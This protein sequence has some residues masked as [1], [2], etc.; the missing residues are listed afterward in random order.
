MPFTIVTQGRFTSAGVGVKIPT[1]SSVDYF[2]TWNITQLATTQAT[3]RVV[4]GEYFVGVNSANDGIRWKKT[5][6]TNVLNADLFST[7]TASDGFN[8]VTVAPG[9]GAQAPNAI[10]GIT[11][12]NPAVVT[13]TNTYSEGDVIRIY[14]TTGMLQ[15]AGMDFQISSVS[16]SGYTLLGLPATTSNG[17]AVAGTAGNTRRI[18]KI[19]AV[20]PETLYITNI[21]QAAA[22]VISTSVDPVIHYAVGMK[23]RLSVPSSMGMTQANNVTATI[24]AVNAV[25]A[26]GNIGAYNLTTDLDS[27]AFTAF[28]F[29]ASTS[30]PTAVLF[31]TLAPAG[32]K[33]ATNQITGVT[34]G[35]DFNLQPF[36]TGEF[37]PFM[38]L[39]GGAQSPA[40]SASDVIVWQ[41]Y[42]METG[43]IS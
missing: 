8:Y 22:A 5:N 2:K 26:T 28:A 14:N 40:G 20:E 41:A 36:R 24:T 27:T 11:A 30:S 19:G 9:I 3:G 42:K 6:S 4:M 37:T 12:A 33:T 18:S 21:S 16:G 13:Q 1:P 29:P 23:I 38:F 35:Y 31:A 7:A 25:A 15:I 32:A 39:A 34:T 43:L 10:T 17:F